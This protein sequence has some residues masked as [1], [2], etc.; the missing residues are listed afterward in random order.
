MTRGAN[1]GDGA[2]NQQGATDQPGSDDQ[3]AAAAA[4]STNT[5]VMA[6]L[7]SLAKQIGDQSAAVTAQMADQSA[8]QTAAMTAKLQEQTATLQRQAQ[9][10]A[11]ALE[12]KL[13]AQIGS[14]SDRMRETLRKEL[15]AVHAETDA[16]HR[17]QAEQAQ[18]TTDVSAR[19]DA[20]EDGLR[21][22]QCEV[23][24]QH[25]LLTARVDA[26]QKELYTRLSDMHS[27][28]ATPS[29]VT[30]PLSAAVTVGG[31]NQFGPRIPSFDGRV[32]WPNYKVQFDLICQNRSLDNA[33]KAYVLAAS[34][35]GPA[36]A[37][38]S[39]LEPHERVNYEAL[40]KALNNRFNEN[41]SA[42]L[43]LVR[44]ENRTR[45]P[46]ES[47][48]SYAA[49][50]DSLVLTA[51]P[52]ATVEC[53]ETIGKERFTRGLDNELR[54]QVKLARPDSLAE[55]ISVASEIESILR[56]ES[57]LSSN[58][59]LR[60]VHQI[61][62]TDDYTR[63]DN[64]VTETR[65]SY[66]RPYRANPPPQYSRERRSSDAESRE[67][68]GGIRTADVAGRGTNNSR[69]DLEAEVLA[70]RA[71]LGRLKTTQTDRRTDRP[72]RRRR[73]SDSRDRQ[74]RDRTCWTCG[75]VGHFSRQ[76][77]DRP[78]TNVSA[79]SNSLNEN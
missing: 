57:E 37:V 2:L 56:A 19:L 28:S 40:A 31:D 14:E 32:S 79:Q 9:D 35:T 11:Q 77:V 49:E 71:E 1:K 15:E 70:L 62:Q 25:T 48:A 67:E 24:S 18:R 20:A 41:K 52:S 12:E 10:A 22:L 46:N 42:E 43:A 47:L 64:H 58:R 60:R 54:R 8:A 17:Q 44:L 72:T 73:Y 21:T 74:G 69:Q 76:C 39:S 3:A 27:R 30:Q 50:I 61:Q 53:R 78:A 34:L 63:E 66:Q 51:F 29:L 26:V 68:V 13:T 7:Q 33:Q 75:Q 23:R 55:T 6:M 59:P 4:D 5:A 36:L 45:G 38:L 16:L 65:T